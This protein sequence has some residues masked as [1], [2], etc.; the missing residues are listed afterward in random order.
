MIIRATSDLHLTQATAPYVFAA[1]N[2][3]REDAE[4]TG[5]YTVL[6]G[7][8]FDQA[9][10]V[11]VPTW[12]RLRKE[13]VSWPGDGIY[14]IAGNH[15]QYDGTNGSVL[16]GLGGH[17]CSVVE[18]YYHGALGLMVPYLPP[19]KFIRLVE[20]LPPA[21]F[22]WCHQG[23]IGA[24]RN[25]MSRDMDGVSARDLPVVD[26]VI[27]G[28]YHMPQVLGRV[29]YCGSPYQTTFA[30]EGQ[31]KGWLRW[32]GSTWP[33]RVA[34]ESVG[35][36][37]HFTI[38]WDGTA[39]PQRPVDAVPGDRL[40]IMT[41]LTR[42][43]VRDR[44]DDLVQAGLEGVPV[45]AATAASQRVDRVEEPI[46]AAREWFRVNYP[47]LDAERGDAFAQEHELWRP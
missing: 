9:T 21:T 39:P 45:L 35:A 16:G 47:G 20:T 33:K 36:P 26:V 41:P 10:T 37:R 46:D 15:D 23:F 29:I 2:Q 5:G 38:H 12:Q 6:V 17:K 32:D 30:E 1:L 28:H 8:I 4:R 43:Q 25:A 18:R 27:T 22:L 11:H 34:F 42:D 19:D 24:Y 3:L 44:A 7:D 14:V 31:T 40:R 13:L